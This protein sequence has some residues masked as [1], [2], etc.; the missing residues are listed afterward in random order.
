MRE[1]LIKRFVVIMQYLNKLSDDS[2]V[3]FL[4]HGVIRENIYDVRNYTGKHLLVDEFA[5]LM[6]SLK[7][8]GKAVSMQEIAESADKNILPN[9][10]FAITFDDG[11]ENNYSIAADI[12]DELRIPATFYITSNFIENNLMSWIDRIEQ[13]I[14]ISAFDETVSFN[15]SKHKLSSRADKIEFLDTVRKTVKSKPNI[16]ADRLVEDIYGQLDL[17]LIYSS[18]DPI[19]NKM[20]WSQVKELSQNELFTIGGHTHNHKIMSFLSDDELFFEID[21][22]MSMIQDRVSVSV[23][24]YSYPEGMSNCYNNKV[25]QALK[26]RGIICCPT[27]IYGINNNKSDLFELRR[28][29]VISEKLAEA[30]FSKKDIDRIESPIL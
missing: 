27:A 12:L 21:T 2:F 16:Y 15:N 7:S 29:T 8:S 5:S 11:F 17:P 19:D 9:K 14:E 25:K 6:S 28:L 20:S 10:A 1:N 23:E 4:F 22:C 3:I 26:K 18:D 13:A 30:S 24:H